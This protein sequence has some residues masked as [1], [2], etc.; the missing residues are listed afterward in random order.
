MADNYRFIFFLLENVRPVEDPKAACKC[1]LG[2]LIVAQQ[3]CEIPRAPSS[4]GAQDSRVQIPPGYLE[5][6]LLLGASNL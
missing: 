5:L 2:W 6:E 1:G 3:G 4:Q